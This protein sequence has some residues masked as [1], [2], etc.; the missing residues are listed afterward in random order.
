M[1]LL[2]DQTVQ[3]NS[4]I[5]GCFNVNVLIK[6]R[7]SGVVVRGDS[8]LPAHSVQVFRAHTMLS[9]VSRVHKIEDS[10]DASMLNSL[11]IHLMKWIRSEGNWRV[12]NSSEEERI[13]EITISL[14]N[15]T[16]D[17]EN[18]VSIQPEARGV[19]SELTTVCVRILQIDPSLGLSFRYRFTAGSVALDE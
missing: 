6:V 14:E 2:I 3:N 7:N 8:N 9:M 15:G 1:S 10:G 12:T 5:E 17:S 13:Q 11:K 18:T 19:G 4:S 16:V